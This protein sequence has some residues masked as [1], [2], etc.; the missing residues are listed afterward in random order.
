M[1]RAIAHGNC[2]AHVLGEK[3][4]GGGAEE[5]IIYVYICLHRQTHTYIYIC[6]YVNVYMY[7]YIHTH[8]HIYTHIYI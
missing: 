6:I 7:I 3:D 2:E 8:I 4:T 5:L 1:K